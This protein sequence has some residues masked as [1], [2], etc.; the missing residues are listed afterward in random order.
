M[1]GKTVYGF[2]R[3]ISIGDSKIG[4]IPDYDIMQTQSHPLVSCIMP[5]ANRRLLV[6]FA[7]DH[8]LAQDYLNRELLILDNGADCIVDLIPA[9]PRIRYLRQDRRAT[10]GA[11]RNRLCEEARGELIAHWDDD[12]WMAPWRLS[13]QIE[14][15]LKLQA[16][17]V[18]V[19]RMFFFDPLKELAWEYVYPPTEKTWLA[20]G[21]LCYSRKFW[22]DHPFPCLTIGEDT[23][24]VWNACNA[25]IARLENNGF[26][27]ALIHSNNTSPKRTIGRRWVSVPFGR[28][29]ELMG[30]DWQ[31]SRPI[32]EKNMNGFRATGR[33]DGKAKEVH[34]PAAAHLPA[35]AK[36]AIIIG[37]AAREGEAA[38]SR[39]LEGLCRYTDTPFRVLVM[40]NDASTRN[41]LGNK[42]I[43][44]VEF[45]HMKPEAGTAHYINQLIARAETDYAVY[46]ES[47]CLVTK[48]WLDGLMK[49]TL[50]NPTHAACGP[51]T[52]LMWNQQCVSQPPLP[53]RGRIDRFA[54]ALFRSEGDAF[55]Y[56]DIL[57]CLGVF[58]FLFN[59]AIARQLGG[60]DEAYGKGPCC[61]ID[62]NTRMAKAGYKAV[63]AKGAYV[64]RFPLPQ[65]RLDEEH[66]LF[67]ASK[68]RYQSAYCGL[69]QSPQRKTFCEHCIG[70]TCRSFKGQKS[71]ATGKAQSAPPSRVT[72]TASKPLVS[73]I[74]PTYNRGKFAAQAVKYF[75]RQRYPL[76]ELIVIDDGSEP[77]AAFLP[78]D[79][80]IVYIRLDKRTSTGQKRNI[81]IQQS[82]GDYIVLWDD[83]DWYGETRVERQ[84]APLI[85]RKA[86]VTGLDMGYIFEM[87]GAQFW[88]CCPDLCS[89]M[90]YA[91]VPGGT[92]AFH[93]DVWK[94]LNGF[95]DMSVAE[96]AAFL[97][98]ARGRYKIAKLPNSDVFVYIRHH[99]NTWKFQCGSMINPLGWRRIES[100]GFID[101]DDMAFYRG[102]SQGAKIHRG[103]G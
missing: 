13:Y 100:P 64:H 47:N 28:I 84:V 2:K 35:P 70:E 91:D 14:N 18:G 60:Y 23:R 38:L 101:S 75:F 33:M 87:A 15:M 29:K 24:F 40:S 63:W 4:M 36:P 11:L 69:R 71:L 95:P 27:A 58:C 93:R 89:R 68:R 97:K 25:R 9:D 19:D 50:A 5:T 44:S 10:L 48:G 103:T 86:D 83:D 72:F 1:E 30:E 52:S 78:H 96:D 26:Y 79:E 92:I 39:C 66:A 43:P 3:R 67:E 45:M 55:A 62:F 41:M 98:K 74:M 46:M 42:R 7:I 16:D 85:E 77:A 37:I 82:R 76:R 21:S 88:S 8:F 99:A 80:R 56:L 51:S 53:D 73:C 94:N 34:N 17:I 49:A 61:E 59:T 102:M 31:R 65:Y 20:G 22:M 32:G 81:A 54:G 12:D 6:P 57:H 90:F